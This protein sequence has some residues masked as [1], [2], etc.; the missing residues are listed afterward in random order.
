[1]RKSVMAVL[2]VAIC[3]LGVFAVGT[4]E[5]GTKR[6]DMPALTL[7]GVR[8]ALCRLYVNAG[9]E[10]SQPRF[11]PPPAPVL[12]CEVPLD[13]GPCD[14]RFARFGF[15]PARGA[16]V[17][18]EWSGCGGNENRFAT[19]E[20]CEAACRPN[21]CEQAIDPGPCQA[22]IPR[23]AFD[24]HQGA[25]VQFTW[26][27]CESNANNF[28]T[29]AA[30]ER[31]CGGEVEVCALPADPGP[32]DAAIERWYS[33]PDTGH[34][35]RFV[36]GG[37][38]GNANNFA[39]LAEC[40]G[41]CLDVPRCRQPA[42]PGPCKAAVPRWYHDATTGRCERFVWGGCAGNDNNFRTLAECERSCGACSDSLCEAGQVCQLYRDPACLE[43][44]KRC[45][46]ICGEGCDEPCGVVPFCA[47]TCRDVRCIAGHHCE[48]VDVAC[49]RG[50][51]PPV[52]RCIPDVPPAC[53]AVQ[54]AS[55]QECEV[56]ASGDPYCADVCA[57]GACPRGTRC[58]LVDVACVSEPCPPVRRCT[59][60]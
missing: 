40:E 38:G 4:A 28:E 31:A 20:D 17:A 12:T 49:G 30:C 22:A 50:P 27:G 18:F 16:C 45:E 58:Q 8:D 3:G 43:K 34:C 23:W 35:R 54:C 1:V 37:C 57:P 60:D 44:K 36:Y 53:A 52:A 6:Q 2:G 56:D 14:G 47:D 42:D 59:V 21:A 5:G 33:D 55:F 46:R 25:C 26:G 51:C 7:S 32:C 10:A 39:T 24:A 9:L 11:C 29:Q 15:D 41:A 48:L 19:K 13:P